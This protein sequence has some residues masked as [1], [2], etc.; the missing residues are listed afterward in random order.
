M[1]TSFKILFTIG[2]FYT[3]VSHAYLIWCNGTFKQQIKKQEPNTNNNQISYS[4]SEQK[5]LVAMSFKHN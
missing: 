4:K 1:E 2:G 5:N 3:R